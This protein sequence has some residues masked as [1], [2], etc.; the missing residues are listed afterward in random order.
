MKWFYTFFILVLCAPCIYAQKISVPE[1]ESLY[2]LSSFSNPATDSEP[3][4]SITEAR[5]IRGNDPFLALVPGAVQLR[6]KWPAVAGTIWGG[7]AISGGLAIYEQFHI[8]KLQHSM[9]NDPSNANWYDEKI[10]QSKRIRNGSLIAL[11]GIY[12]AN[13]VT[14]LLLPDK[15][16]RTSWIALYADPQGAVGLTF[17]LN[18]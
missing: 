18:F 6:R 9:E 15:D 2:Y 8:V 11:G 13:Y 17:A 14:A 5:R 16:P 4:I 10:R 12:I 3:Q 1:D 7:M